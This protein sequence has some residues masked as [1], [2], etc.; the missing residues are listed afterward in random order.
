[1]T[2]TSAPAPHA[3]TTGISPALLEQAQTRLE[4]LYAQVALTWPGFIA[5]PGQYEM[6]HAA[7]LTFLSA[8]GPDVKERTGSN[9]AELEAGTGTGKTVAYC[10]AAIVASELLNKPVIVSTATVALQ[11][12]LFYKD[13]P[14]LAEIIPELKFD[15]LKG[16]G[17][18][19]C[20]SRLE[21]ALHD[22]GQDSLMGAEFQEAFADARWQPQGIP[23][24]N[25]EALR[26]FKGISKK[27]HSGK[28]DGDI[29]GLDVQPD[30][31]DW[32]QVQAIDVRS[33]PA[34]TPATADAA[35]SSKAAP[36]SK[37]AATPPPPHCKSPTTR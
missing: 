16:R 26:W 30:P 29:D 34:P 2:T 17:R 21:G 19:I 13:L 8:V 5:R 32:R 24:D 15:I 23:R 27:L 6:M 9:L 11:E 36:S 22:D 7:L 14:R 10:L 25:A 28:W 1:M 12:Q 3:S 31:D 20:E 4:L 37:P 18:Y 33:S 35:S